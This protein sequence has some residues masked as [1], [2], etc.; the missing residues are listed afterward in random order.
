MV[1]NTY[2]NRRVIKII[3]NKSHA[4]GLNGADN[5]FTPASATDKAMS[6]LTDIWVIYNGLL[7]EHQMVGWL[8]MMNWK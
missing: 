2:H 1:H 4:S 3:I 5:E 7:T 8:W 6:M